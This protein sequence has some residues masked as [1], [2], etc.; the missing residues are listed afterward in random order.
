MDDYF[1]KG[2]SKLAQNKLDKDLDDY[3]AHKPEDTA[4]NVE[5]EPDTAA[6]Q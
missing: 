4:G 2:D 3:F 6:A 1:L 5:A